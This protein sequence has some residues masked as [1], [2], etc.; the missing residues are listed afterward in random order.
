MLTKNKKLFDNVVTISIFD[1]HLKTKTMKK[2]ILK[3]IAVAGIVT[4]SALTSNAQISKGSFMLGG[5]L[6]AN[7]TMESTTK[8]TGLADMTRP[9][10]TEWNFS[11]TFGYF[12]SDGLAVGLSLNV[13]SNYMNTVQ[14]VDKTKYEN[15]M[16]S[17]FGVSL[18]ARKYKAITNNVFF[19][20]QATLGY[21][22]GSYTDRNTAGASGFTDGDKYSSNNF[23][24][25]LSPGLTYFVAPKWG[26]DFSLNNIIGYNMNSTKVEIANSSKTSESSGGSFNIG[27]GLVPTLGVFYYFGK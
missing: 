11:P 10:Y 18:F 8:N 3:M 15:V 17:N 22:A 12:V 6:G 5:S 26:I 16:G 4:G 21:S 24:I 2:T 27:V 1:L 25:S 14:S 13:S 9:G 19:H 23:G 20:G 7:I